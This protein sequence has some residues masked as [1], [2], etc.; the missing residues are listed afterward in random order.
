MYFNKDVLERARDPRSLLVFF[1]CQ[2]TGGSNVQRWLQQAIDPKQIFSRRTGD[3]FVQ[4]QKLTDFSILDGYKLVAG[5]AEYRDYPLERPIIALANAR[6][7]F[8]R[9]VSLYKMSR[10]HSSHFMH[11]I[12][13]SSSFEDW[14]RAGRDSRPFYFHNL[15]CRRIGG[16]TSFDAA[17]E[18]MHRDFGMVAPTNFLHE[19]TTELVKVLGWP[20]EPMKATG[21]PTDDVNYA[22]FDESPV[23]DEIMA[24]NQEDLKLFDY[25]MNAAQRPLIKASPL[26]APER[27][28]ARKVQPRSAVS[29]K[30]AP[31]ATDSE[32]NRFDN[33]YANFLKRNPGVS[34][35]EYYTSRVASKFAKGRGH[36]HNSLGSN[37]VTGEVT[38][39]WE[40]GVRQA[41]R[42]IRLGAV[43]PSNRVVEYGCG[44]LRVGAHFIKLL[45]KGNFFGLDI[46]PDFYEL[47]RA[48]VG[49]E[50]IAAKEPRLA[51]I[52][53][54]SVAEAAAFRPDFV[55]SH[56]VH[57]H[58]HPDDQKSYFENLSAIAGAPGATLVFNAMLYPE[59]I[60]YNN[61][62]WAWP[63]ETFKRQLPDFDCV[64]VDLAHKKIERGGYQIQGAMLTFRRRV[65]QT[66]SDAGA[67]R[68]TRAAGS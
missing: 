13:I 51:T 48:N 2:R 46:I 60:R 37:I 18:A 25:V 23:R 29:K 26:L 20:I 38:E 1:H 33:S 52:S 41:Q 62:G 14:Y 8:Y 61:L 7:P 49:S 66:L 28:T 17:T 5:F 63:E 54:Q 55:F 27:I 59:P 47:G 40:T 42:L 43:K 9:I 68:T 65:S 10:G 11:Q 53:P 22:K 21:A 12:A 34:Y 16:D 45:D 57:L 4:W 32:P 44:S 39:F 67:A 24:K 56:A 58:V 64:K 31:I 35:S 3:S 50:L 30:K 36:V 15:Q 6:H 19:A